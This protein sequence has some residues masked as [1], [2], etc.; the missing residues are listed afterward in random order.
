MTKVIKFIVVNSLALKQSWNSVSASEPIEYFTRQS[1]S[2][3]QTACINLRV[4]H[5]SLVRVCLQAWAKK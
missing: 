4:I 1:H 5:T 3:G 2:I